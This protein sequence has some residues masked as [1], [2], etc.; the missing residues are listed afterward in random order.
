MKYWRKRRQL[1]TLISIV[2]STCS[3]LFSIH[4]LIRAQSDSGTKELSRFDKT[5]KLTEPAGSNADN[6]SNG[7]ENLGASCYQNSS[8]H[9]AHSLSAVRKAIETGT[10]KR[11]QKYDDDIL[12]LTQQIF[13]HLDSGDVVYNACEFMLWRKTTAARPQSV[14]QKLVCNTAKECRFCYR[15][16]LTGTRTGAQL[17]R[18]VW[19]LKWKLLEWNWNCVDRSRH[20]W[21]QSDGLF[22]I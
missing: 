22:W 2:C 17:Q 8:F 19:R 10:A 9:F 3:E 12:E 5:L 20:T 1:Q 7:F 4:F 18:I 11:I 13:N 14:F 16:V 6:S 15:I 21:T